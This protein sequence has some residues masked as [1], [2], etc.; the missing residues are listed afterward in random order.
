MLGAKE[1]SVIPEAPFVGTSARGSRMRY[2]EPH[3]CVK[4]GPR[5]H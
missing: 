2:E 3:E 1:L 5:G 4:S